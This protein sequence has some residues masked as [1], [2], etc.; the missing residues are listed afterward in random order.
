M[1]D[2]LIAVW[3]KDKTVLLYDIRKDNSG[4]RSRIFDFTGENH[5]TCAG[6]NGNYMSFGNKIGRI[7]SL[8]LRKL[9]IYNDKISKY[10]INSID[11]YPDHT[12]LVLDSNGGIRMYNLETKNILLHHEIEE[13]FTNDTKNGY[14][15]G[16]ESDSDNDDNNSNDH[17]GSN[18][19]YNACYIPDTN[20]LI[21]GADWGEIQ[22]SSII[23]SPTKK[24]PYKVKVEK[25]LVTAFESSDLV[26]QN[27]NIVKYDRLKQRSVSCSMDGQLHIW[28]NLIL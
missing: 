20:K 15:N 17:K 16:N 13:E 26:A 19:S 5:L 3:S 23:P 2:K 4:P 6:F 14:K 10:R 28:D 1:N 27:I 12:I 8:D 21:N 7:V 24:L 25:P 11:L 9:Y 22:I 18:I